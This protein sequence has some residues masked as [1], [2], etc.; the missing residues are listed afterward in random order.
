MTG[1]WAGRQ[2][3]PDLDG[4]RFMCR[5]DEPE[6]PVIACDS[7]KLAKDGRYFALGKRLRNPH[8]AGLA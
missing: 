6:R 5:S 3:P 4:A 2:M 7:M 1:G 8:D